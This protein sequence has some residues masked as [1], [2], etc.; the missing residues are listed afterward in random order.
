MNWILIWAILT[1]DG[2]ATASVAFD[3]QQACEVAASSIRAME[4]RRLVSATA[5]C[6]KAS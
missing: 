1:W 5:K 3:S 4:G 6:F 2:V